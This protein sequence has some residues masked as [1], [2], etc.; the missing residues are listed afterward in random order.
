MNLR[1]PILP[2]AIVAVA[3]VT[4][5]ALG[6]WQLGRA[7]TKAAMIAEYGAI[8]A[9]APIVPLTNDNLGEAVYRPVAFD[10]LE[11]AS[12]RST[13][14]TS[15]RGGKGWEHVAQCPLGENA[16]RTVEV[17]LGWSKEANAPEWRGG[18]VTGVLG[19]NAKVVADPPLAGLAQLAKPDPADLPNNHLA[20]AGQWF[21]FALT[22]LVIYVLALRYRGAASAKR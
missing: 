1:F 7:D 13:A 2:T 21:L 4:M 18:A 15:A 10:C 17:A 6:F 12:I 9:D 3:V 8:P 11:V 5:I 14:G 20:Y 22:A 19:Q 16:A